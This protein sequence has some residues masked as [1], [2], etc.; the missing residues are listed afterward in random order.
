VDA[1]GARGTRH[2]R[3]LERLRAQRRTAYARG[4]AD[5]SV[6]ARAVLAADARRRR[7]PR[8]REG[9]RAPS[10]GSSAAAIGVARCPVRIG[11]ERRVAVLRRR[12]QGV[13]PGRLSGD[14][15]PG[16]DRKSTR[17]NSSHANTSYAVF[18]L[19]KKKLAIEKSQPQIKKRLNAAS[20]NQRP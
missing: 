7:A 3:R 13:R 9:R 12:P 16:I 20:Q 18:C 2:R 8:S 19:K 14:G 15:V 6:P 4:A 17:L 10:A 5:L 11:V 1:G